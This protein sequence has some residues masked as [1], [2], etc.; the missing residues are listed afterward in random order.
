MNE[1]TS[2]Q[3]KKLNIAIY[4]DDI[5]EYEAYKK[6]L[7]NNE[8]TLFTQTMKF[9]KLNKI[10]MIIILKINNELIKYCNDNNIII[11]SN[12]K[13]KQSNVY[14][15]DTNVL[16]KYLELIQSN[17]TIF[18]IIIP[19]VTNIEEF[20]KTLKTILEQPVNNYKIQVCIGETLY[21]ENIYKFN[22]LKKIIK[23]N[24][25][26]VNDNSS[27]YTNI[28][29]IIKTI[30]GEYFMIIDTGCKFIKN[31]LLYDFICVK[32]NGGDK[33]YVIQNK[34]LINHKDSNT[35]TKKVSI[36]FS[37]KNTIWKTKIL[38]K[39]GYFCNNRFGS[40]KEYLIR[41]KYFMGNEYIYTNDTIT[42]SMYPYNETETNSNEEKEK[43]IDFINKVNKIIKVIPNTKIYFNK[44]FDYFSDI[45]NF[46][47]QNEKNQVNFSQY[48]NFYY[49]LSILNDFE[50][51]KHWLNFGKDEGR[52]SNEIFFHKSF[53]NF[54]C[55]SYMKNNKY[56]IK[57][58]TIEY[59][60]GWVYLKNKSTYFKWLEKNN[61]IDNNSLKVNIS[62]NEPINFEEYIIRYKIKY[63]HV[64]EKVSFLK[65]RFM[66]KFNLIEYNKLSDKFE[67]TLFIGLFNKIDYLLITQHIGN[68]Y[69]MWEG[70]DIYD[71]NIIKN[72]VIEKISHYD[73]ITHL[74]ASNDIYNSLSNL[75]INSVNINLNI[76]NTNVFKPIDNYKQCIF[77][78]NGKYDND[79]N[80]Y[81]TGDIY[82]ENIYKNIIKSLP[83]FDYIFSNKLNISYEKM[84]EIYSKCFIGI[85]LIK[86]NCIDYIVQ[87]MNSMNVPIIYNG[88]GGIKWNGINDIIINIK[89]Q[90]NFIKNNNL[91][92]EKLKLN[93]NNKTTHINPIN[94]LLNYDEVI[95]CD[96]FNFDIKKQDLE[97]IYKNIDNFMNLFEDNSNILFICGD[98]PGYGG[99][100]TNCNDIQTFFNGKNFNTYA[101]YFNYQSDYN[102]KYYTTNKM[103][104][105]EQCEL[106][107][108]LNNLNFKPDIII[109]KS[110][111][112]INLKKIFNCP[113]FFLIPG[114]FNNNL[115]KHYTKL[116][117]SQYDEY[118]N[119]NILLNIKNY[120]AAFTNSSHTKN[121]LLN[122][123]KLKTYLFY[124]GFV[125]YHNNYDIPTNN[126]NDRKYTYGIIVSDFNRKIKNIEYSINT[127]NELSDIILI[128]KNSEKYKQNNFICI[129]NIEH[130]NLMEYY[131]NIKYII[132]DSFYESCS[133]VKIE[134]FM[135]GCK[136][137]N[138]NTV[139]KL[140]IILKPIELKNF[141]FIC[142]CNKNDDDKI[143]T[144][145]EISNLFTNT[146]IYI[147]IITDNINYINYNLEQ[148]N[149]YIYELNDNYD[150]YDNNNLKY[151][152][153]KK[154]DKIYLFDYKLP[155]IL[156]KKFPENKYLI[157]LLNTNTCNI[158]KDMIEELNNYHSET[159]MYDEININFC[160]KLVDSLYTYDNN[161]YMKYN[162]DN[163]LL[164]TLIIFNCNQS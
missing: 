19:I 13:K 66:D 60:M 142:Y 18:T 57:F 99:A 34:C 76:V 7:T 96:F 163:T 159:V 30:D 15:N 87:E 100:A 146:N 120:D 115:D 22:E 149:I 92:Y 2:T 125:Q 164:N 54:D 33:Y 143:N 127:V 161:K 80:N 64:S 82:C 119:H 42:L 150:N 26:I 17:T 74:S 8:L 51:S 101:I 72:D 69:L 67:N 36:I 40:D 21:N 29:S 11:F 6:I 3:N 10:S 139:K 52:L 105:I 156:N 20:K 1:N 112:D 31:K 123:Y 151:F 157:C 35:K 114:I 43:E 59:V 68:K 5:Q 90:N 75:E 12:I 86:Y 38:K 41:A 111:I 148:Q 152:L 89:T 104:I 160:Y 23:I 98:Y 47:N 24:F 27:K 84:A 39:I 63:I 94:K 128:G 130:E 81:N 70:M 48:K 144:I 45:D 132:Q 91:L 116:N 131:Q 79:N 147:L 117:L 50:L 135:N 37:E 126:F 107:V 88:D 83:E 106:S 55:E 108:K 133:N 9:D 73:N 93:K 78:Y 136:T 44:Y 85:N 155:L 28:N 16:I 77:I 122:V 4:T 140:Q 113:V 145:I 118:I 110:N 124:S 154:Y 56:N 62:K 25:H 134:A 61:Y 32:I 141:L 102:K 153:E 53:P 129:E 103:K 162:I 158:D 137:I 65:K 71:N 138:S 46:I 121:T 58:D 95:E 97:K 109:L 14:F 49:D